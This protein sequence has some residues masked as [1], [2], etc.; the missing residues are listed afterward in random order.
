MTH[1]TSSGIRPR[2]LRAA[3]L[4]KHHRAQRQCSR[5]RAPPLNGISSGVPSS[6]FPKR[7]LQPAFFR[8]PLRSSFVR[9]ANCT[10]DCLTLTKCQ[11]IALG[12]GDSPQLR[13]TPHDYW[14][15]RAYVS[16]IRFY[17]VSVPVL[18][19]GLNAIA[20]HERYHLW[21]A[22]RVL[23][24]AESAVCAESSQFDSRR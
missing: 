4:R 14:I 13:R 1:Y 21:Q 15:L 23:R 11:R 19:T 16:V 20:A 9:C 18:A 7:F 8:P 2:R 10:L 12:S 24:A 22:W 17:E 3:F 6:S 5:K